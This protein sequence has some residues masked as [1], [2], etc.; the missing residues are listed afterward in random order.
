MLAWAEHF[1]NVLIFPFKAR[2][3]EWQEGHSP[4]RVGDRVRVIGIEE[5]DDLTGVLVKVKRKYSTFVFPLCD[6]KAED[7][8]SPNHDPVQLYAVWFANR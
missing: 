4:L 6:L 3:S 5:V 7:E 8:K 2:V 1:K